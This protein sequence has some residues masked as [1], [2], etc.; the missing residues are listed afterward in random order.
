VVN[1]LF[2]VLLAI[3]T[4]GFLVVSCVPMLTG[5]VAAWNAWTASDVRVVVTTGVNCPDRGVSHQTVVLKKG[6][7]WL[8]Q[9]GT[10]FRTLAGRAP[11][12]AESLSVGVSSLIPLPGEAQL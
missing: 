12:H 10:V 7:D 3:W 8:L 2:R 1:T 6:W 5:N 11:A 9:A 4:I